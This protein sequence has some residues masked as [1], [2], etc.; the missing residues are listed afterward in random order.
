[1][2][3]LSDDVVARL[4][5]WMPDVEI[6][7]FPDA[8]DRYV[9]A[10]PRTGLLVG[11]EGSTFATDSDS[12][13]PLSLDRTDEIAVTVLVRSLRGPTGIEATL[14]RVRRALFGFTPP[15]GGSPLLPT[16]SKFVS[17]TE[18]TWRF[19]MFFTTT[20]TITAHFEPADFLAGPP[21]EGDVTTGAS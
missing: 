7:H 11:Y 1:M 3:T 21:V 4:K 13:S 10:K 8:P 5:K 12:I 14:D 9:W 17:E 16:T 6:D 2:T 20:T 18:G 15:S 19:A